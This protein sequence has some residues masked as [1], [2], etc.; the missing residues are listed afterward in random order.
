MS[1]SHEPISAAK[2]RLGEAKKAV[3]QSLLQEA[4]KA[5]ASAMKLESELGFPESVLVLAPCG[6]RFVEVSP[7]VNLSDLTQSIKITYTDKRAE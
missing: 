2:A 6:P 7:D 4:N 3:A 5:L 1:S